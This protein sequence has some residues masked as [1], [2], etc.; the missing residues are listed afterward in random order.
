MNSS[1][2]LGGLLCIVSALVAVL[3][4]ALGY[5]G[6]LEELMGIGDVPRISL[7]F[8]LP[9]TVI[10]LVATGL[11]FWLGWIMV[12]TKEAKPAPEPEVEEEPEEEEEPGEEEKSEE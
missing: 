1:R 2:I 10:V 9:L 3:H 12:T 5:F 11:G 4:I 8:A 6:V 7:P